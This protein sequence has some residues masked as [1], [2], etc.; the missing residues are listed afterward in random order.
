MMPCSIQLSILVLAWS[1]NSLL[2][3][4]MNR[5]CSKRW[6]LRSR[7][8]PR[9][10]KPLQESSL[11][12][13]TFVPDVLEV[14]PTSQTVR[15]VT[16]FFFSLL[17]L[18]G[19]PDVSWAKGGGSSSS[20]SSSSSSTHYREYEPPLPKRYIR[21]YEYVDLPE[22]LPAAPKPWY[23]T[24]PEVGEQVDVLTSRKCLYLATSCVIHFD[25]SIKQ[26]SCLFCNL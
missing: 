13:Q 16:A 26:F 1:S 14:I 3:L 8:I 7:N 22:N 12:V 11:Q 2:A 15:A 23:C 20:S 25:D 24:E 9:L 6:N 19:S 18:H 17:L 10:L 4:D 21:R 5:P